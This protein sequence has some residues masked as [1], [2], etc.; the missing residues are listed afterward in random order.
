MSKI[1]ISDSKIDPLR[2]A[3]G[4]ARIVTTQADGTNVISFG[5]NKKLNMRIIKKDLTT[6]GDFYAEKTT[7]SIKPTVASSNFIN[8]AASSIRSG[9]EFYDHYTT[10]PKVMQKSPNSDQINS[11]RNSC[12]FCS[13][14]YNY[15]ATN[16]EELQNIQSERS[17]PVV[18]SGVSKSDFIAGDIS[19]FYKPGSGVENLVYPE[20]KNLNSNKTL[21]QFPFYNKFVV[22]KDVDPEFCDFLKK[23]GL[24]D[25][26]MTGYLS[27]LKTSS[28][29]VSFNIQNGD[30]FS[31][32]V[33]IPV[34]DISSW[35][36][37]GM[38]EKLEKYYP[39]ES[40]SNEDSAMIKQYK[41]LLLAGYIN[42]MSLGNFRSFKELLLG[43]ES[44]KQDFVTSVDK[45]LDSLANKIQTFFLPAKNGD[46]IFNDTQIKYG[47]NYIYKFASHYI[48]VGNKYR[49]EN[50]QV[51][52]NQEDPEILVDVINQPSVVMLP[53]DLFEKN[54]RALQ[55]PPLPPEVKFVTQDSSSDRIQLYFTS[56]KGEVFGLF[57]PIFP[58]DESQ[59]SALTNNYADQI[60]F[61]EYKESALFEIY[62]SDTPPKSYSD[63]TK[64]TEVRMSYITPDAAYH[65]KIKP[66]RSVYYMFR[67]VNQ[68]GLVSNATPIYEVRLTVDADD[69]KINVKN[70]SFPEEVLEQETRVFQS[71]FQIKPSFE[72]TAF[73]DNQTYIATKN[74]LKGTLDDIY[75]G[76]LENTIWGRKIKF[77]FKSTTTGK[78]LDY[79]ITF[80][81]TKN[82]TEEDL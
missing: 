33:E 7:I 61:K 29:T 51:S 39:L 43:K 11:T 44:H 52:K 8:D 72:Q 19:L 40:Q 80:K 76:P 23:I 27:H 13:S 34:F 77:R 1:I 10:L 81:L 74:S 60:L 55:P 15:A 69:S 12:Y 56:M 22:S 70:Y 5:G 65:T 38:S 46:Y 66:N 24:F 41:K 63:F 68:K 62:F 58:S 37:S 26:V 75:L 36:K 18:F 9:V 35:L 25:K 64:V 73:D 45:G 57:T 4:A 67:K 31:Q 79:N 2:S 6:D 49:Y 42:K 53:I 78:I 50:V 47:N 3:L 30:A 54:L 21:S 16:Y 28:S 59:M 32:N 17:C 14:I 71:L 82:K 48:I 20:N